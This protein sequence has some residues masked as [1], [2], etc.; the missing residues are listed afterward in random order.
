MAGRIPD[1]FID[2]VLQRTDVVAIVGERVPLRPAGSNYKARCPFHEERTPSFTVSPDRQTYHCFGCGAH[3]TAIRFLMEHDRMEFREAVQ[4]LAQR[5]GLELPDTDSGVRTSDQHAPLYTALDEADRFYRHALRSHPKRQAAVEYLKKRGI[6]GDIAARFGLGYAPPGWDNLLRRFDDPRPA[7]RAGLVIERDGRSYDRFRDRITF[8]IHDR[9]GRVV[10]FGARVVT[11]GEPKYLN[12]PE[13]PVFHKGREIYGLYQALRA[14]A[15]RLI[16]VEGY[17]DVI[18]LAQLG[19]EGAVATLGTATSTE[20]ASVLLR[21]AQEV[22]LCFDG[23]QPGQAAALRA[24]ENLLPALQADR[25]VRVLLL[26]DGSDPDD[27]VRAEGRDSFLQRLEC[28]TPVVDFFLASLADD[29]DLSTVDGRARLLQQAS[30]TLRRVPRGLLREAILGQLAEKT[31]LA[32]D[33]L[34]ELLR[35]DTP[36]QQS[37][38]RKPQTPGSTQQ[39]ELRRTPA[40]H[41]IGLLLH[42]PQLGAH[43]GDPDR[44]A[45]RG[46]PGL[47]LLQ[48]LLELT[49]QAPHITTARI[50]ERFRDSSYEAALNRLVAAQRTNA[51]EDAWPEFRDALRRIEEQIVEQE[52]AD[53]FQRLEDEQRDCWTEDE[54][55]RVRKAQRLQLL[56]DRLKRDGLTA[57]QERE[58]AELRRDFGL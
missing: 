30:K 22:I 10:G 37:P 43:A 48:Q 18:A 23:D 58:I 36:A 12:S 17:M 51:P 57:D 3:G 32:P 28:A 4:D 42:Q 46:I 33:R 38:K 19:I 29:C 45:D 24:V 35:G 31:G 40:R 39:A 41:A 21:S 15:D 6:S 14:R 55:E 25:Q 16:V 50:L 44:F 54:E 34:D 13:T 47:D 7:V 52:Q 9:R 8:P 27:L 11:D 53:L 26:P 2:E 5:V 49:R 1:E 20:Q 56:M